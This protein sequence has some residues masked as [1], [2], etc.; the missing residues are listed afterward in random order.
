VIHLLALWPWPFRLIQD[1]WWPESG[2]GYA[3]FSSIGG[4]TAIL[5]AIAVF[6]TRHNCHQHRCLRLAWHPDDEG[7]PVCKVHH[8]D[9][10]SRGW[11]RTDR[12]HRR[13]ASNR[14]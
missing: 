13:H 12:S 5:G 9:H 8:K 3:I 11:F 2:Y 6:W 10:P 1:M 14:L 7:H 4:D